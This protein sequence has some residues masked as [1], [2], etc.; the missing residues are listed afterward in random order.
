MKIK[1]FVVVGL[2]EVMIIWILTIY[3]PSGIC[4]LRVGS[5]VAVLGYIVC[6]GFAVNTPCSTSMMSP[7]CLYCRHQAYFASCFGGLVVDFG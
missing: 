6:F 1:A 7:L 4:L 3:I 2:C 5:G